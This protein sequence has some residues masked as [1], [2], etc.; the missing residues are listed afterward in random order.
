MIRRSFTGM[1]P[2]VMGW[3]AR[4]PS[5]AMCPT[6]HRYLRSPCGTETSPVYLGGPI[7][8]AN[9]DEIDRVT[10]KRLISVH[11]PLKYKLGMCKVP[12]RKIQGG[13]EVL[14]SYNLNASDKRDINFYPESDWNLVSNLQIQ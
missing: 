10:C 5:P 13:Q 6:G 14:W 1:K 12:R 2:L 11:E 7:S 9:Y 8:L 3:L 4:A